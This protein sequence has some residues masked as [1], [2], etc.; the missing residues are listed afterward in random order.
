MDAVE[1]ALSLF[2]MRRLRPYALAVRWLAHELTIGP[3]LLLV[4]ATCFPF[5][6]QQFTATLLWA[7]IVVA[8]ATN[9][10]IFVLVDRDEFVS[11]VSHTKPNELT[12]DWEFISNILVRLIP[13]LTVFLV[14][15]PGIWYWLRSVLGPLSRSLK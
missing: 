1:D 5:E 4:A 6:P 2:L 7:F 12:K 9:L 8:L 15:F 13:A 10:T 14:A 11:S 3:V